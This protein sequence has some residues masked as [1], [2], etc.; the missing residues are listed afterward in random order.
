M[1]STSSTTDEVKVLFDV[2]EFKSSSFQRVFQYLRR[3]VVRFPLD[4]FSYTLGSVECNPKECL[5]IL[6]RYVI[7]HV[8]LLYKVYQIR[9]ISWTKIVHMLGHTN[10]TNS[11]C[12]PPVYLSIQ[13]HP[14]LF[15]QPRCPVRMHRL[16]LK[17]SLLVFFC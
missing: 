3:H 8:K 17:C 4:K 11:F 14:S 16:I 15:T 10:L 6:L 9:R 5:S 2:K 12:S 13:P 7:P 1:I